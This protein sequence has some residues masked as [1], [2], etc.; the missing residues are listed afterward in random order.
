MKYK[1]IHRCITFR[2]HISAW[3]WFK[4]SLLK[5]YHVMDKASFYAFQFDRLVTDERDELN[6]Y[7]LGVFMHLHTSFC[8]SKFITANGSV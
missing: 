5:L 6:D 7:C 1:E 8:P 3:A 4:P 2:Q